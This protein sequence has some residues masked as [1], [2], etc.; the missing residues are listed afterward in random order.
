[1]PQQINW[2][3]IA[4]NADTEV[5]TE[6]TQELDRMPTV[7]SQYLTE[8]HLACCLLVDVS[9]SMN[10]D[11]K[12]NQLNA[13][14]ASFRDQ[15]CRDSL[16]AMRVEVSVI[17]FG[18]D[19]KIETPFTPVSQFNAP[20]LTASGLTAMGKGIR[21]ALETVHQQV[22]AYHD[23]GIECFKPFVLM[24]TDGLP[25]DLN[26][27]ADVQG[28]RNLIDSRE[29][30]GRFG[31]LRFHAFAVKP[32]DTDFLYRL[33]NRVMA[34]LNNDFS[35]LF[36]WASKTMQTISHSHVEDKLGYANTEENMVVPTKGQPVTWDS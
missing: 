1:M 27:D 35:S 5:A 19:V 12:I 13:A 28:L 24:I 25:T 26:D 33:T 14:L 15:V 8:P 7:D 20:V 31:H 9:D 29:N 17:S 22:H 6:V 2:N 18:S 23:M 16:S 3:D 34:V 4:N 10:R 21:Y 11:G 36:N 30:E 32:G